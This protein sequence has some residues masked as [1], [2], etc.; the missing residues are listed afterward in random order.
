MP[1]KPS[2][3]VL[4]ALL[5]VA[6][7]LAPAS[8]AVAARMKSAA[9]SPAPSHSAAAGAPRAGPYCSGDYADDLAALSA[10]AREFEQQQRPYTY[11]VRSIAV[12]E[13]PSYAPDGSL[14]K[15]RLKVAAHGTAFGYRQHGAETLLVTNDHVAEWPAVTSEERPV[16]DVPAGCKRVSDS[17]RIVEDESDA[18]ERDDIPL[19]RVVADPQLDVAVLKA[20]AVLPVVPWKIGH[21][22]ALRER[23]AVDVRGFPLGVLRANNVGKVVSAYD[24]DEER[25]WDHDDF[26]IDALL[27][28]GNSGSPVFAISCRTGEFELVGVYHAGYA[29][30]AA[31]NVVVGVDQFRDLLTTLKR[32]RS[33]RGD[34]TAGPEPAERAAILAAA[35]GAEEAFFPFGSLVAAAR[36][37]G[38]GAIVFEI[39]GKEFPVQSGPVLVLEDLPAAAGAFGQLGRLWAGNRQGLR[40]VD[41]ATL[42]AE[43]QALTAKLL[44]ALRHDALLA[45]RHRV[46]VRQGMSSRERFREVSRLERSLRR[47]SDSRQDLALAAQELSERL[48]PSAADAPGTIA[49]ALAVPP[50]PARRGTAAAG[51]PRAALAAETAPAA[52]PASPASERH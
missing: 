29:K 20:K 28:P 3:P 16:E 41:H 6:L 49:E 22:A 13:C 38:D 7:V 33:P 9:K 10:R 11:C 34:A 50:P 27:S 2:R 51:A 30:G 21:S 26:V 8:A 42:D 32:P 23:N 15:T 37:R 35:R 45:A 48:C 46:A 12:Y 44:D 31:L 39:M 25:D 18:Y 47:S 1:P 5:A 43:A 40:A 36:A 24:H 14:R 19:T 52:S 17:L 4:L